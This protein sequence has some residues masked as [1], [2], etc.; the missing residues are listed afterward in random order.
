MPNY[1]FFAIVGLTAIL[2][3]IA[4]QRMRRRLTGGTI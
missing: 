3:L 4:F 2:V 1:L